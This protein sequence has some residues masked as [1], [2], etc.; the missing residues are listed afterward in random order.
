[1]QSALMIS[2]PLVSPPL[3][4]PYRERVKLSHLFPDLHVSLDVSTIHLPLRAVVHL[5]SLSHPHTQSIPRLV[6]LT[7]MWPV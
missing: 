2:T 7:S 1:M 3:N 4:I 6:H 5:L